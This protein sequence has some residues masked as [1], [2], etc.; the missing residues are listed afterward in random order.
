MTNYTNEM[1]LAKKHVTTWLTTMVTAQIPTTPKREGFH[2]TMME[3]MN[4]EVVVVMEAVVVEAVV[5][6]V[7]VVVVGTTVPVEVVVETVKAVV[8]VVK[9][10][11]EEVLE[12]AVQR[13]QLSLTTLN[14]Y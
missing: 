8:E 7:K 14:F 12:M 10:D 4:M 5:V 9:K 13:N 2:S 6:E 11:A 1:T 3:S